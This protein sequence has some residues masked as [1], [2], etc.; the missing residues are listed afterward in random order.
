M[1]NQTKACFIKETLAYIRTHKLLI[2]MCL[3][4]G[5]S[6]ISPLILRGL[7]M[8]M[9][10]M[11]DVYA[12][13]DSDVSGMTQALTT[14]VSMGITASI[15]E[16]TGSA[17]I[18]TLILL[19][20]AAGG[21]QKKRAVIIPQSSGLRSFSYLLPKYIIYP[22][23][24]LVFAITATIASW[25]VSVLIFGYNDVEFMNVLLAGILAGVTLMFYICIHLTIGTATGKAGLS[26]AICIIMSVLL[27]LVFATIDMSYMFNPFALNQIAVTLI[28]ATLITASEL[29]DI[30]V[31]VAFALGIMILAFFIALFAQN[32][33]KIDNTG[34]EID[35]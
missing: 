35:L 24:A 28:P 4:M 18:V 33:R 15:S 3:I 17:L 19:N 16:I 2:I 11:E 10:A 30:I 14:D 31:S 20:S 29:V 21:E 25:A 27:P 7:G 9:V 13:F 8:L 34:N 6:I 12:Q 22:L 23:S 32:S 26:A 5:L 1:N